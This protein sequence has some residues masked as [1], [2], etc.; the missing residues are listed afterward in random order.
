MPSITIR[1][2]VYYDDTDSGGVVYHTNYLKFME[3]ARSEFLNARGYAPWSIEEK[4][5]VLFVVAKLTVSY[6]ASAKLGDQLEVEAV[7]KKV[8]G[9]KVF[10]EQAVWLLNSDTGKR[11][12]KLTH[13]D[14]KVVCLKTNSMKPT[15]IP[16]EIQESILREH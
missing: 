3:H 8:T 2:R 15:R 4:L 14:V 12:T 1:R 6:L 13:A 16:S 9:V 5:G 7:I 10:F 11:E